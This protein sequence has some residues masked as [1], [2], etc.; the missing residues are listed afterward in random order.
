MGRASTNQTVSTRYGPAAGHALPLP[1][2]RRS[3]RPGRGAAPNAPS[4]RS[5]FEREINDQC[6][7]AHVRQQTG[8]ALL[9]DCRA[10]ELV[11]AA[12]TGGYDVESSL[13]AGQTPSAATPKPDESAPRC[14]TASTTAASPAPA[15]R[16][17]AASIPT[18]RPAAHE[19]GR[20]NTSAS[21]PSGTPSTAPV[22]LD[23]RGSRRQPRHLRLRRARNLL[24]VLRR[25]QHRRTRSTSPA[26]NWSRAW[27]ARC[28]QPGAEPAGYIGKHLSA[29]GSHFIFGS[30]SEFESDGNATATSRSTTAIWLRGRPTSSP[31]R[32]PAATMTGAGHR[33]ARHLERRLADRRRPARLRRRRRQATGT[34]T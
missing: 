27:P 23:A 5:P 1:G 29:D 17:T 14:S 7:N 22:Q 19:A 31:R 3:T 25:R 10:Y 4:G 34:S 30:T 11:S 16:R 2:G 20:P 8:A 13:V 9:L 18:W 6:P 15:I 28:T 21:P 32:R 33:R 26:A 24:A 12:N